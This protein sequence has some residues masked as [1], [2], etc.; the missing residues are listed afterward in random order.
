MPI[1]GQTTADLVIIN[2]KIITVDSN[3]STA[4]AVALKGDRIVAVG[5]EEEVRALVGR[6]TKVF[7]VKGKLVLPGI[8]DA[9]IH[10]ALFGGT[11]VPL[12]L[13]VGYPTVKSISD[14]KNMVAGKIKNVKLG[15][16]V[17]G[18]GWDEGCLEECL[19][20]KTRH[21]SRWDLD[22]VSPNNPVCLTDSSMHLV[23]VNSKAL[24]MAGVTKTTFLPSGGEIVK[25]EITGEPTGI[26]KELPAMGLV[27]R[28]VPPLNK[29]QK[30]EAILRMMKELNSLGI[31]SITEPGLGPGGSGYQGGLLGAEC[32]SAY[33]DLY[34]EGKLT[35]RV[36]I[37]LLFG[38]YGA[39]SFQD[40]KQGLPYI[41]I[42]TGFGNEWLRIAGVKVFADG[43]PPFRTAWM[44]DE[45]ADDGHGS[46]VFPGETDEERYSE[47]INIISYAHKHRFQLGIHACGD[48]AIEACIDG[49][50]KAMQEETWDAR[51]YVIHGDF[52]SD[53]DIRRAAEY[54]IGVNTL[55]ATLASCT[56]DGLISRE[57]A[58]RQ[59]PLRKLVEAGVHVTESSDAPCMY[60]NWK[61]VVQAAV[62]REFKDTGKV[63]GPEQ[64]ITVEEAI[65]MFTIEGAWQ[66]HMEHIK[67]SIEVGKLADLCILEEDILTVEPHHI[68]DIRNL[69]TIAGGKIV[70]DVGIV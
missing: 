51:H 45:Y 11:R 31:T 37:L 55:S 50:I 39:L 60:P 25:D 40:I 14:I 12:V 26:L 56:L 36:N 32:I 29:K 61:E 52:I 62:L 13:D 27:M 23:W 8:N 68:K 38:N 6:D 44:R 53:E 34:N 64:C 17:L 63:I 22:L 4:Q 30:R 9:H 41:G 35:V 66:D 19:N 21:P 48:R 47:L 3:F 69:M 1:L 59:F 15:E 28:V 18:F 20:D 16:W 58:A 43:V 46:L 7:D 54:N 5:A 65:R 10:A 24:E 67:G 33:N 57:K 49:Y 70:Y 2:G 42:H